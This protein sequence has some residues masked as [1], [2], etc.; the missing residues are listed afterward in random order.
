MTNESA[1]QAQKYKR[2][3]KKHIVC[4]LGLSVEYEYA[5]CELKK[6]KWNCVTNF[7]KKLLA[8]F[9]VHVGIPCHFVL[10]QNVKKINFVEI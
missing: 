2:I 3:C 8:F 1:F 6:L 7:F 4:F 5:F 10:A 9:I